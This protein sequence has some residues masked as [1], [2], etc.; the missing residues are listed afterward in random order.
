MKHK[1][2]LGMILVTIL[3]GANFVTGKLAMGGGLTP[4][5]YTALRFAAQPLVLAAVFSQTAAPCKP[6]DLESR[7]GHWFGRRHWLRSAN[8]RPKHDHRRQSRFSHRFIC[9]VSAC[10]GLP[11]KTGTAQKQ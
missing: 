5:F 8:R 2:E 4:N 6:A 7:A 10:A 1:A 9:G 11:V 3:W